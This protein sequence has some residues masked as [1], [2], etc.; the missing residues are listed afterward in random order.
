MFLCCCVTDHFKRKNQVHKNSLANLNHGR[1]RV[2]PTVPL[3]VH[4]ETQTTPELHQRTVGT[5][6]VEVYDRHNPS[7]AQLIRQD[8]LHDKVVDG[9]MRIDTVKPQTQCRTLPERIMLV[10]FV[11]KHLFSNRTC[12]L[13]SAVNLANNIF[14]WDRLDIFKTISDYF[15]SEEAVP[16]MPEYKTRGRGAELFKQRYGDFFC[17]LKRRHA[18]EILKYVVLANKERGGMTT[19]GR[20]QAHLMQ[21]FDRLFN[22]S[23]I[24]YCLAKRLKLKYANVGKAKLV[25]SPARTRS[26]IEFCKFYDGAL[27]LQRAGTHIIVYMDES[28]CHGNHAIKRTWNVTGVQL[29]RSR[30]KGGLTIIVHAMTRDGFLCGPDGNGVRYEVDEWTSGEHP[31]CEM[32]FRSKYATKMRI[33]DYHDTMTGEFFMYCVEKRLTPAFEAHIF[34]KRE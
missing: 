23:T 19:I 7:P 4:T 16:V 21:T 32:V 22:K 12:T 11:L 27:K 24:H 1:K 18:V 13:T 31:T 5:S 2:K 30:G 33:K 6:M 9:L 25:F 3:K 34:N 15:L 28:Y 29:N 14:C 8:Q 17:V 26:A 10:Q 20:I